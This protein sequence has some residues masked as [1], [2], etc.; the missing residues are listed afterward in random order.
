MEAEAKM[1]LLHAKD[2][3]VASK[4][5]EVKERHRPDLIY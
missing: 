1:T 4:P 5:P 3:E 2:T